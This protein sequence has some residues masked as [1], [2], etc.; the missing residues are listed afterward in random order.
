[1]IKRFL[2]DCE[3]FVPEQKDDIKAIADFSYYAALGQFSRAINSVSTTSNGVW[4]HLARLCVK[5]GKL[6]YAKVCLSKLGRM[7]IL[8][9]LRYFAETN[10]DANTQ[11]GRL[12]ALL[13][14]KVSCF[15]EPEMIKFV[16][17][18]ECSVT[19]CCIISHCGFPQE[20]AEDYLNKSGQPDLVADLRKACGDFGTED[21]KVSSS[22]SGEVGMSTRERLK[23]RGLLYEQA[24]HELAFGDLENTVEK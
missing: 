1:M 23:Q 7:A 4:N 6:E 11:L 13:Q 3:D 17:L 20:T 19:V 24:Q 21:K 2:P 15:V 10:K 18:F 8:A 22:V 16:L 12:A 5:R 9:D 14:M